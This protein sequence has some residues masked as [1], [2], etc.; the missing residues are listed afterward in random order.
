MTIQAAAI[1]PAKR[2]HD[3]AAILDKANPEWYKNVNPDTIN[4]RS[5]KDCVIGQ[6]YGDFFNGLQTIGIEH[7]VDECLAGNCAYT[8]Y[9]FSATYQFG[10]ELELISAWGGSIL[11]RKRAAREKLEKET[12]V[13]IGN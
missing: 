12:P 9:G 5:S 8:R 7:D 3:G 2:V 11:A 13:T 1:E 10:D 4:L 6:L